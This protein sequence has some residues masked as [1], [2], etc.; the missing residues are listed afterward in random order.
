MKK[1]I[2]YLVMLNSMSAFAHSSEK[3]VSNVYPLPCE[4]RVASCVDAKSYCGSVVLWYI[5]QISAYPGRVG[6]DVIYSFTANT[7]T[8]PSINQANA[9]AKAESRLEA[10][11]KIG[12][13]KEQR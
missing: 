13:C 4:V 3:A 6:N 7:E 5:T 9:T 2:S 1:I 12:V 8:A 10:L 11:I